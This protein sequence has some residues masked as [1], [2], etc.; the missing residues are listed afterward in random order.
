MDQA[1]SGGVCCET[2]VLQLDKL[3]ESGYMLSIHICMIWY[4][5]HINYLIL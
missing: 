1:I 2:L 3:D 4:Y 5:S